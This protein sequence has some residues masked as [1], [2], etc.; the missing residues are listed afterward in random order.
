MPIKPENAKRYPA[1]WEQ[2]RQEVLE[3]AGNK[4]EQCGAPNHMFRDKE[5]GHFSAHPIHMRL[6]TYIV[7]TIAHRDHIPENVGEPGNR[8]NLA[9]WCQRCHLAYDHEHH[10]RNAWH[11]RREKKRTKELF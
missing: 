3:R 4:C 7:L 1:D 11:T 9:A 2:I 8:P 10:Q 6:Q 5:T